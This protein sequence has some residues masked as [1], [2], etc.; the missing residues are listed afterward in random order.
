MK[1]SDIERV[2]AE[3]LDVTSVI[4]IDNSE[5]LFNRTVWYVFNRIK[6]WR[7]NEKISNFTD[8]KK[9]EKTPECGYSRFS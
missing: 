8:N 6:K 7:D 1:Y 4:G 5:E 3:T 2:V 9:F